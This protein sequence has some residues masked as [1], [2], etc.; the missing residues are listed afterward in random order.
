M[1]KKKILKNPKEKNS[2]D[3]CDGISRSPI[4]VNWEVILC[5]WTEY[6]KR[7]K[8]GHDR[9]LSRRVEV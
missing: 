4:A 2:L 3:Y 1:F 8:E 5:E 7:L 6:K 9:V